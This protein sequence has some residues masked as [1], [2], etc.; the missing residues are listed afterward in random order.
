M[1]S[2]AAKNIIN[3]N[4]NERNNTETQ[5]DFNVILS[6]TVSHNKFMFKLIQCAENTYYL[7]CFANIGV[8][9]LGNNEVLLIDSGDHKKSVGDLDKILSERGWKVKMIVNTHAHSDHIYGNEFFT[10]KYGCEVYASDIERYLVAQTK[11]DEKFFYNA[12][13]IPRS[14]NPLFSFLGTKVK[15]L[16]KDALPKGFDIIS[17]P[18]HTYN[19]VG[20]KTADNVWFLGDALLSPQTFE[21]Y[22]IP[23]NLNINDCIETAK[24]LA[25]FQGNFFVPSHVTPSSSI[26]ELAEFNAKRLTEIK[27]YIYKICD[28][29]SLEEIITQTDCDMKLDLNLDKYAK[30]TIST[31]G[32]LQALIDDGKITAKIENGKMIYVKI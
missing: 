30:I 5:L 18:G 29:K 16:T 9:Y 25:N 27:E 3:K 13:P 20:I 1:T 8:Y 15:L 31:K 22:K 32:Y 23:F 24:M 12:V 26:K 28:G 2:F 21:G 4:I 7:S 6:N 17:L 11:I 10:E 19:M 14:K